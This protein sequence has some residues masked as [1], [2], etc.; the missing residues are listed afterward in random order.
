MLNQLRRDGFDHFAD[1]SCRYHVSD[2]L[3]AADWLASVNLIDRVWHAVRCL[4]CSGDDSKFQLSQRFCV[5]ASL[6]SSLTIAGGE[7][8]YLSIFDDL[9]RPFWPDVFVGLQN[10][11]FEW[12]VV[13]GN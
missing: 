6:S 9:R 3:Y 11:H 8:T 2:I 4:C 7:Q 12:I 1:Y 5:R 13:E 10:A